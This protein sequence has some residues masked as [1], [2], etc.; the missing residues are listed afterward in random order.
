MML[1]LYLEYKP[2]RCY[3][4]SLGRNGN[5][6]YCIRNWV[7]LQLLLSQASQA[8]CTLFKKGWFKKLG[9]EWQDI[10]EFGEKYCRDLSEPIE[11]KQQ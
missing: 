9:E 8:L 6:R 11:P 2:S 5:P 1:S 4:V 7:K 3:V 10:A